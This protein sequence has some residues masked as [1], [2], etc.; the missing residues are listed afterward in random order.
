MT[1]TMTH[2]HDT[3]YMDTM[4]RT[5]HPRYFRLSLDTMLHP[6]T[7]AIMTDDEWTHDASTLMDPVDVTLGYLF[8]R[9]GMT[10]FEAEYAALVTDPEDW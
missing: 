9:E 4:L 6:N 2:A 7:L 8:T 1:H 3:E 10:Y 5:P